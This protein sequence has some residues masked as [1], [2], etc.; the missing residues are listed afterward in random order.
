MSTQFKEAM[1]KKYV[2]NEEEMAF[3]AKPEDS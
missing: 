3:R 2:E 1:V